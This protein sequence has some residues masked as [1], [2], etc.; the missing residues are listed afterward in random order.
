VG[1]GVQAHALAEMAENFLLCQGG[2]TD[3]IGRPRPGDNELPASLVPGGWGIP[4]TK[5]VLTSPN[6]TSG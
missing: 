3:G 4:A 1:H 2:T 6:A 5:T